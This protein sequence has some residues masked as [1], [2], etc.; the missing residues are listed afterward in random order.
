MKVVAGA[1]PG[2]AVA[3]A[4][5]DWVVAVAAKAVNAQ[6]GVEKWNTV[7]DG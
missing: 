7:A 2:W 5:P 1:S 4:S 6:K 3:A